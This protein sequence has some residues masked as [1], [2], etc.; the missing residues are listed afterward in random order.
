MWWRTSTTRLPASQTLRRF[1]FSGRSEMKCRR[2]KQSETLS[3]VFSF[4]SR[5][6]L[7][8]AMKS[9]R[10]AIYMNNAWMI[11]QLSLARIMVR[12]MRFH[13]CIWDSY[14]QTNYNYTCVCRS[15]QYLLLH[16]QQF[17]M[18]PGSQGSMDVILK[19]MT[20]VTF[21]ADKPSSMW[22]INWHML[23]EFRKTRRE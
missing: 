23:S 5:L 12:T 18:L 9:Q 16:I 8:K 21:C 14:A 6:N 13:W 22:W 3:C 2:N 10:T 11:C 7:K 15:C 1:R 20:K 19:T 17:C 4:P